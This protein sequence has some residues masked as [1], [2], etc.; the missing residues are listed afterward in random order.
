MPE[1]VLNPTKKVSG[2]LVEEIVRGFTI[3]NT[4]SQCWVKEQILVLFK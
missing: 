2:S 3:P 4:V 1:S